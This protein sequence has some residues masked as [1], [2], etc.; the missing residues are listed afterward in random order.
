MEN[1][2]RYKKPRRTA[3]EKVNKDGENQDRDNE[4]MTKE[5]S[6]IEKTMTK[7]HRKMNKTKNTNDKLS[8]TNQNIVGFKMEELRLIQRNTIKLLMH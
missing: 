7:K 3:K 6:N 8:Q 2:A 4:W 5:Y 1:T